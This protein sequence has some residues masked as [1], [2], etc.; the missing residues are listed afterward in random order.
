MLDR[1][2]GAGAGLAMAT[3]E[4][5]AIVLCYRAEDSIVQVVEPLLSELEQSGISHELV[6]VA[7][8]HAGSGDRTP[9]IV[10]ALA[11]GRENVHVVARPKEGAMGWDMRSGL[12]AASGEYLIVIDGDG[13]NPVENVLQLHREMKRTGADVMKGRRIARFDGAYRRFISAGYN[14][15]FALLFR[16]GNLRDINAKPKGMTRAAY[17]RLR[18]RSDDWFIDAEIVIEARRLGLKVGE[19]PVVFRENRE[20]ASF[21]KPGAIL[22]FLVNMTRHRFRR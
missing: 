4:L 10:R 7:N 21:V 1:E 20:R 19:I 16:T 17:E 8:Y 6:L 18:L 22:E 12:S 11:D 15:L 14:L 13:Q 5:S 9:E 2:R 3:P